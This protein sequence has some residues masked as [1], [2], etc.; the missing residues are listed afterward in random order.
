M[1]FRNLTE[2]LTFV[3]GA[4]EVDSSEL[5]RR[6]PCAV[7]FDPGGTTGVFAGWWD[8]EKLADKKLFSHEAIVA[9]SVADIGGELI[10][11]ATEMW[12]IIFGF[13]SAADHGCQIGYESFVIR[14]M[15]QSR[16]FLSPVRL[17]AIIEWQHYN[18]QDV[19]GVY[20]MYET[21]TQSPAEAKSIT[22]SRLK[23]FGVY[24]PGLMHHKDAARHFLVFMKRMKADLKA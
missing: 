8:P 10:E 14:R 20:P 9:W 1:H 16:A 11:Q 3:E 19:Y 7:W 18:A 12:N 24:K 21:L 15:D 23:S 13:V 4:T 5:F 17:G 22:D 6:Y 2:N